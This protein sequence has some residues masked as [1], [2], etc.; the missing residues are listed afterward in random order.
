[1]ADGRN[2]P[3]RPPERIRVSLRKRGDSAVH[4]FLWPKTWP[5]PRPGDN[6]VYGG[7]G[8]FVEYLEF[9]VESGVVFVSL[10]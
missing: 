5:L 6:V 1:M 2:P 7:I 9:N 4:D 10:R 8:G 3:G